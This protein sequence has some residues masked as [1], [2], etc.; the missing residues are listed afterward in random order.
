MQVVDIVTGKGK[1]RPW[2]RWVFREGEE[3]FG[4]PDREMEQV[5]A[6]VDAIIRNSFF[7]TKSKHANRSKFRSL[8]RVKLRSLVTPNQS[9]SRLR[10]RPRVLLRSKGTTRPSRL[11]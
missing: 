4:G 10:V 9:L 3:C 6:E 5:L 11:P 8:S 7:D 2:R 1:S